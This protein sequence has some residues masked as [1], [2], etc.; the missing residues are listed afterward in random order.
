MT[1]AASNVVVVGISGAT[2]AG[3]TTLSNAL[4]SYVGAEHCTVICQDR[5]FD[6]VTIYRSLKGNWD[7][8]KA[9]NHDK[10]LRHVQEVIAASQNDAAFYIILEGFMVFWSEELVA[11]MTHMIWLEIP[12][13]VCYQRRMKTR[14]ATKRYFNN[15]VWPNYVGY[16]AEV[17]NKLSDSMLQIDGT[18]DRMMILKQIAQSLQLERGGVDSDDIEE[19]SH[20]C[21]IM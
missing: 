20:R 12:R 11:L 15:R 7:D 10:L 14:K 8:P 21:S 4:R 17:M 13:R 1:M 2:R 9:L 5:F 19:H 6:L 16:R 18:M 3:K